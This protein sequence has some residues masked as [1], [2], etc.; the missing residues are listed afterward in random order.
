MRFLKAARSAIAI[1]REIV[2]Q[3]VPA[4]K[5]VVVSICQVVWPYVV[6][7]IAAVVVDLFGERARTHDSRPVAA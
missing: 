3:V 4:V 6:D 7:I 2:R 5:A 1:G